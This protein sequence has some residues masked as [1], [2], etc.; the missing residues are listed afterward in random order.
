[1]AKRLELQSKLEQLMGSR[2]VYYQPPES[3][4]MT[5]P[6]IRYSRSSIQSRFANDGRY[7]GKTRYEITVIDRKPDNAAIDKILDLPF[8][9][10]D[11]HYVSDNLNHDT[12]T[13]YY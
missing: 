11:R 1:M 8:C 7:A 12:F 9:S 10:Y 13:L 3:I 4:K 6:A 2:N 5:Y